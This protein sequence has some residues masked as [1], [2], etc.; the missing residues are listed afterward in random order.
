[1]TP[2]WTEQREALREWLSSQATIFIGT[3]FDGTLAPLQPHADDVSLPAGTKAVLQQLMTCPGI[4]LAV[5]S[6]RSLADVRRRV[7]LP[8][9]LY[10]GNHGLEM[11][12]PDGK[13][14]LADGAAEAGPALRDV[15]AELTPALERFPG[16]WIEDKQL[17]LSVHYRQAEESCYAEV[18]HCVKSTVRDPLLTIRPGKRIWEVRP[19]IEWHKG[20]ALRRFMAQCR[21]TAAATA[22]LGDDASDVDAFR[23]LPGGW[24][25]IVGDDL[26]ATARVRLCDPSDSAAF[27]GW[28]AEVRTAALRK[29]LA[30]DPAF[31][32]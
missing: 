23:E 27:L 29:A 24:T 11:I 1:M 8:G 3:D 17:T 30:P 10:A 15:L 28:M 12:G 14:M 13:T 6:G 22:F 19:A 31:K 18:E 9:I 16:V 5:I 2:H 26:R 4:I 7:D 32:S 25:F 21:V 20:S